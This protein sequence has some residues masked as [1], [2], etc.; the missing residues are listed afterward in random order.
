ME[1]KQSRK[2]WPWIIGGI[3]L[4][5]V[6]ACIFTAVIGAVGIRVANQL[7]Q[8]NQTKSISMST[9]TTPET[10]VL[11]NLQGW[12]EVESETDEWISAE[13]GQ[14]IAAGQHL[15]TG[16]LSSATLIFND[17]SQTLLKA[18]SEIS[19]DELNAL[20][21]GKPRTIVMTQIAGESSHSVVSNKHEDSRY[22][23][24]TPSGAG[25]A[26]G[27][28]F[29]VVVTPQQTAYY[30]V[31]D[32]VVEVST[33]ESTVLVN[34][35]YMTILF[36]NEPPVVPMQTISIEG[37]VS[38]AGNP[39]TVAGTTF[40]ATDKTVI[41][42]S[43][44][45]G[46]WV[47]VKGHLNENN[48]NIADWIIL[49]RPA[50]TN[51]FS[52]TGTVEGIE[53]DEWMIDGQTILITDATELDENIQLGDTV[54]VKGLIESG[55][56]L[57]ALKIE[58]LDEEAGFPFEFTG[59]VQNID[60]GLWTVSG[61]S[62]RIN[63]STALAEGIKA[64]DRVVVKGRIQDDGSW[65]A[66]KI[67]LAPDSESLFKIIGKLESIDPW[68]VAGISFETNADTVIQSDLRSGD[69]ARV[70]GVIDTNGSWIATRIERIEDEA[71][72][73]MILIGTVISIDPWIV[74]GMTL[75]I[76]PDAVI[77][78]NI[79][80]G[81]LVRVELI[82]Q[83][84][85]TW[86]AIKIEPISSLVWFPGCMDLIATVVSVNGNQ[87]QLRNWP[88][89]TLDEDVTIEGKLAPDSV[90]RIRVCF[91]EVT[92]IK[93]TYIIII[94]QDTDEPPIGE[95][96]GKVTVCHKPGSKKGGHTLTIGRPALGAHLGHGDYEGAC[97]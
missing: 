61:V 85:G 32:G 25:V 66:H 55:S 33:V 40:S 52:L 92:V 86:Q 80:V 14:F 81:M 50:V 6:I 31:I 73:K 56:E 94:Q 46:D 77:G 21:N 88:I 39:W 18:E 27:T 19:L 9:K 84:D 95:E 29:S 76:A 15:R 51:Q 26:K 97:R 22:A 63:D 69:L 57:R 11:Q 90:I 8:K 71:I 78:E 48:E 17:G 91:T 89:I 62:I 74:N 38:Q 47:M 7:G 37:L 1:S 13:P 2:T 67:S 20:S 59:I 93:V 30:Y 68:K 44:Q 96:S 36:M 82:L 3:S 41:V 28:E 75:T 53:A 42:G 10:A 4:L 12:V 72:S 23:V 24:R 43:P 16:N 58:R 45:V 70:E 60:E 64:G 54:Y 35:G 87:L 49:L 34:P 79:T 65:L 83:S 5:L